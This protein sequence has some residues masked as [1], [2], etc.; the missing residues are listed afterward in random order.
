MARATDALLSGTGVWLRTNEGHSQINCRLKV[1]YVP[2]RRILFVAI[3]CLAGAVPAWSSDD[4]EL[5]DYF[6]GLRS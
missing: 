4:A 1:F 2:L 6:A 5:A 3:F